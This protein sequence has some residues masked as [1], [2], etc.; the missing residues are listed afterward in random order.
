MVRRR[1]RT[2]YGAPSTR[3]SLLGT[4]STFPFKVYAQNIQLVV[5]TT[6][7]NTFTYTV[8]N[9]MAGDLNN[10]QVRLTHITARFHPC[11]NSTSTGSHFSAQLIALDPVGSGVSQV[12]ITTIKPL[13]STNA[14]VFRGRPPLASM[15]VLSNTSANILSIAIW[16][17]AVLTSG[18][19]VDIETTWLVCQDLM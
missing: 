12:P 1:R 7:V 8:A 11:N 18:L 14:T 13:S 17:E 5:N 16:A 6:G 2:P 4:S 15:W 9:L 3:L 10:R 19:F